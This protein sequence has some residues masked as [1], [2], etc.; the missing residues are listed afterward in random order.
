MFVITVI[1]YNFVRY[2]SEILMIKHAKSNQ[3]T[4]FA[5]YN[6]VFIVTVI[7]ITEFDCMYI[8]SGSQTFLVS[9]PFKIF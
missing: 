5:R 7:V 3:L 6:R 4:Y 1:S 9:A 2:I 8:V